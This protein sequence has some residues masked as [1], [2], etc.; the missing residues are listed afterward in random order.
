[1]SRANVVVHFAAES[2]VDRSIMDPS[3]FIR[4]NVLGT[5]VLLAAAL[6]YKIQRFHHI[7][8]DEVF[9]HL[10][11]NDAPFN[12]QTLLQPRT[13]YAASKA[14]ADLLVKS[15]F[16]TYELPIT[17][18]NCANNFGPWCDPEKSRAIYT[19]NYP[20]WTA[21]YDTMGGQMVSHILR[22]LGKLKDMD[23]KIQK[24]NRLNVSWT[25][26]SNFMELETMRLGE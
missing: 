5:Q 3:I 15:Y 22:R 21:P 2:H 19:Q 4:T 17:I 16:S 25:P 24:I 10:G 6:K 20:N 23:P 1:M 11:P 18:T 12:E 7:S 26:E 8:T 13:P 14:G 9:G